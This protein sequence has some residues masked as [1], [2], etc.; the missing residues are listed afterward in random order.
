MSYKYRNVS[1][2]VLSITAS[3]NINPRIVEP[4]G[5]VI[6]DVAIENP[7]FEYVGEAAQQEPAVEQITNDEET[8]NEE[9]N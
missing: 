5:E 4:N 7:N 2:S 8:T 6:S 3:G 9:S 1:D